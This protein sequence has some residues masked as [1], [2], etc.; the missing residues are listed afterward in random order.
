M[1]KAKLD[2]ITMHYQQKG[3]GPDVVLI[4]GLTGDLSPWYFTFIPALSQKY[5]VTA[6][7]LRGH[8]LSDMPPSGYNSNIMA[9]DLKSLLDFLRIEKTFLVGHSYGGVIAMAFASKYPE[10]VKGIIIYDT[11]F[12]A[13][14]RFRDM[15]SMLDWD[16]YEKILSQYNITRDTDFND[17]KNTMELFLKVPLP[18]GLRKGRIRKNP[19]I[20][21]LIQ[22]TT[23]VKEFAETADLTEERLLSVTHPVLAVYG[24]S[25]PVS[26]VGKHLEKN[27]AQCSLE[28]A[29]GEDHLFVL[30][31][32]KRFLRLV[33]DFL[34]E[35][36]RS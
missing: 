34:E 6:Y 20:R 13:L 10:R 36:T 19:R 25:S 30:K 24:S 26:E 27:L 22:E 29:E 12:P 9:M 2:E 28:Y 32:P 35:H 8:G 33:E 31:E 1:A 11:G 18:F 5:R 21:K 15:E 3:E 14:R 16:K 23:A 4:H 17:L 7:D